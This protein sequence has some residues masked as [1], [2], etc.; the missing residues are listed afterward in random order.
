VFGIVWFVGSEDVRQE[1]KGHDDTDKKEFFEEKEDDA[2]EE[3]DGEDRGIE[4]AR[5][6][7]VGTRWG[8]PFEENFFYFDVFGD[9]SSF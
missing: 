3:G 8:G 4:L 1:S 2:E 6:D 7:F 9:F 5:A